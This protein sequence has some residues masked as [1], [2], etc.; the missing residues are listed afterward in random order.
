[1]IQGPV[2]VWQI[3]RSENYQTRSKLDPILSFIRCQA[4]SLRPAACSL[5]NNLKINIKGNNKIHAVIIQIVSSVF[6]I[7]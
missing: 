5:P 3:Y 1:M 7:F 4:W 2:I 6:I